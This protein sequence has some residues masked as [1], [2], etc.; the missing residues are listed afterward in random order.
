[1]E[2]DVVEALDEEEDAEVECWDEERAFMRDMLACI[3]DAKLDLT[4]WDED[5][6]WE[7][8]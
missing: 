4:C 8:V 1:M 7:E 3:S 2:D 5:C 6:L